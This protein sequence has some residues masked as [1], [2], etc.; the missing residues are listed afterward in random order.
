[1][2]NSL[3]KVILLGNL[4]AFLR[5]ETLHSQPI[6]L[7]SHKN[8][9]LDSPLSLTPQETALFWEGTPPSVIETYFSKLP[10]QLTS[11]VLRTMRDDL[12]K[13]KYYPLLQNTS[14]EQTL[15]SL[16]RETGQIEK[17]K[18]FLLESHLS[19]KET[20]LINVQW[21]EGKSKKVCEKISNLIRT[22]SDPEWK[23]QNIYCLILNGEEER[24]KIA[25]ELL[26]ESP[27]PAHS[28]INALFDSS[29][30]PLFDDA[31]ARSPF[32]LTVWCAIGREIPEQ[33]LKDIPPSSLALIANSENML[34]K[35]RLLAAERAL[36]EGVV[37]GDAVFTLL[38]NAPTKDF[39]KNF[40]EALKA[41]KT[42]ILLPLFQKA[43]DE[44]KLGVI[45]DIF[46]AQLSKIEPSLPT[47][48]LAPYMIRAFLERGE[49]AHAKKWGAFFMRESP[50][51]ALSLFPLLH[52]AFP[53]N[54]W[55]NEQF[56]VWQAYQSR[57]HPQSA[58][59]NSYL[60][61]R[62][63][64]ALGETPRSVMK[65]EPA[66]PSWRQQKSFFD[67]K[68]MVLLES[69]AD[70]K[71][72]GEVFLLVLVMMGEEPFK[73]LSVDKL[74]P[75]LKALCKA[76]YKTEARSLALEFLLAKDL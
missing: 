36:Q 48:S 28:L 75:I 19:D 65:G 24:A 17:A 67:Q 50:D 62:V 9:S 6:P 64:E 46:N 52:L 38:K 30:L 16:L 63:F 68:D 34:L 35:T 70:S 1:M 59:Q 33:S 56:E 22:S 55:K 40:S 2:K 8:N 4:L 7:I 51:E 14:Y 72:K 21:L 11:R 31:I 45:I 23:K 5:S 66:V 43:T 3:N 44:Y 58:A 15:F 12:L 71:R 53:Q 37:K 26:S 61:R 47:L 13:E 20:L 69:A 41:S 29:S 18:E 10:L 57:V 42:E 73:S 25:V 49:K 74:V 76:G 32:L 54:M 27:C 60:L 39:L